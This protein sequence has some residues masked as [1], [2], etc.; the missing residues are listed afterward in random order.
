MTNA[1]KYEAKSTTLQGVTSKYEESLASASKTNP[2]KFWKY[3]STQKPERHSVMELSVNGNT[4]S[5]PR[6]IAEA[7]N[8]Q[9]KSV[10]T[11][12]E[13]APLPQ[14]PEY[15]IQ[16]PMQIITVNT[17]NVE[18]QL[19]SMNPNKSVGPDGVHPQTLKEAHA[20]L[21]LLLAKLFQKSLDTKQVPQDWQNANITPVHKGGSRICATHYQPISITSTVSKILE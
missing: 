19:K 20:E 14:V 12:P 8:Q 9:F 2:K 18:S 10:F 15:D 17:L 5:S 6:D 7:L 11:P 3:V 16:K 13:D 1:N 21:A 4:I